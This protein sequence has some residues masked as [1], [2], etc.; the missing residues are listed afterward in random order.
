MRDVDDVGSSG[1]V[2][3]VMLMKDKETGYLS[4]IIY[5]QM[6][7]PQRDCLFLQLLPT[8]KHTITVIYMKSTN[9]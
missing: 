2:G 6:Q 7:I 4:K 9:I 5:V 1:I 3:A 8:M